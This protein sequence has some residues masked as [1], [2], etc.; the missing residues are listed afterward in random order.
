MENTL[1]A[2]QQQNMERLYANVRS[3]LASSRQRA[4]TAVNFA[5]VEGY[6][7]IGQQIVENEL[8]GAARA[9]Y[10]KGVLKELAE[11]LT[12]EFGKGF[13]ERELRKMRQFYQM[14]QIRDTLRPELTWSHYPR[15]SRRGGGHHRGAV[16]D[17]R[18][19]HRVRAVWHDG[20]I[21][22]ARAYH[23]P[24]FRLLL[25]DDADEDVAQTAT[26]HAD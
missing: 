6:W 8:Q 13:D 14:F 22:H 23:H 4:Y 11:R 19:G 9:E 21:S 1:E 3:I 18:C 5:M 16:H 24:H 12:A 17:W 25:A 7:L 2:E 20:G 15:D 26:Q 10:G